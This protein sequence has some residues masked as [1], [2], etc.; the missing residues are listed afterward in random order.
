MSAAR[1]TNI[2]EQHPGGSDV[3]QV[4]GKGYSGTALA[5]FDDALVEMVAVMGKISFL[6]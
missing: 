4:E 3:G 6:V 2:A 5:S 1:V